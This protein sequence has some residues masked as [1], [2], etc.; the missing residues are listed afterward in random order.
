MGPIVIEIPR[1]M[2]IRDASVVVSRADHGRLGRMA[3]PNV[4]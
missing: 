2:K 1:A 3:K 4:E